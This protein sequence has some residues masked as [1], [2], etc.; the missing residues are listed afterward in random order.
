M[1]LFVDANKML[2]IM[3]VSSNLLTLTN[4]EDNAR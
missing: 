1:G 2:V 4:S 3:Q